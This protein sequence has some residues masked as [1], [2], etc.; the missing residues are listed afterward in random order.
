MP[1]LSFTVTYDGT[2]PEIIR[3][4]SRFASALSMEPKA[5]SGRI[6][7]IPSSDSIERIAGKFA[8]Y[9]SR[10]SRL[11]NVML[12]WL[13]KDGKIPL[14]EL[15]KVSGVKKQHDYAGIGSALTRNMKKAG[16]PKDWY[17]GAQDVHGDWIYEI[18]GE[19]VQPLKRAFKL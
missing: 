7:S 8:G 1:T 10:T 2:D 12:A 19:L 11:K 13:R 6:D 18:A 4:L 14:P 5:E 17:D 3:V 9:V 15:V 16:G